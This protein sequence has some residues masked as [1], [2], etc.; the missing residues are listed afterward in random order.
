MVWNAGT[1]PDVDRDLPGSRVPVRLRVEGANS[2]N[3]RFKPDPL[4]STRAVF[5][6]DDD[7][8][9]RCVPCQLLYT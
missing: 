1:P 3:N 2:L 7:I 9:L 8:L 5:M 4:L 6:L